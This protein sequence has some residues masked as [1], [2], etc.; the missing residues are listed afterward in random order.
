MTKSMFAIAIAIV[1]LSF[2]LLLLPFFFANAE[3]P[4]SHL[5]S[6]EKC[7]IALPGLWWATPVNEV[8][9]IKFRDKDPATDIEVYDWKPNYIHQFRDYADPINYAHAESIEFWFRNGKLCAVKA[10]FTGGQFAKMLTILAGI[11]VRN[12]SRFRQDPEERCCKFIFVSC[13]TEI[14]A[15]KYKAGDKRKYWVTWY[16]KPLC[17]GLMEKQ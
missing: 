4:R 16:Y 10:E 5:Y 17:K 8:K 12:H 2:T 1:L 6:G 14:V 9:W 13:E 7:G 3:V 15:L 11:S